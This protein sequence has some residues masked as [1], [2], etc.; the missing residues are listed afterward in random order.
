MKW[1]NT[2]VE[3]WFSLPH[4]HI[5]GI[6]SMVQLAI[7]IFY[8]AYSLTGLKTPKRPD[9]TLDT[10]VFYPRNRNMMLVVLGIIVTNM[11]RLPSSLFLLVYSLCFWHYFGDLSFMG[12]G[13]PAKT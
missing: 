8:I 4:S 6:L 10:E 13:V 12:C 1:K 9:G 7:C 3:W 11:L 2:F 5:D